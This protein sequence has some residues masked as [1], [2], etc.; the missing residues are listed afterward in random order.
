MGGEN[1]KH[2]QISEKEISCVALTMLK[3]LNEDGIV[4]YCCFVMIDEPIQEIVWL[5]G[6]WDLDSAQLEESNVQSS[7]TR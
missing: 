3:Q 1:K 6:Y 5:S 7:I 4:G 2:K